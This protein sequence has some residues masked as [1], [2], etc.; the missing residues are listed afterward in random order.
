[1]LKKEG[2][3]YLTL[4]LWTIYHRG[5]HVVKCQK[6]ACMYVAPVEVNV[7]RSSSRVDDHYKEALLWSCFHFSSILILQ[8]LRTESFTNLHKIENEHLGSLDDPCFS[9]CYHII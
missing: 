3:N 8:I 9:K 4:K 7:F 2:D 6:K 1:M 5:K